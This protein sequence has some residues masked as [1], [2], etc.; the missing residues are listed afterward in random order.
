MGA[1][2]LLNIYDLVFLQTWLTA[3]SSIVDAW[4]SVDQEMSKVSFL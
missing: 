3:K 4:Q 1:K 2:T